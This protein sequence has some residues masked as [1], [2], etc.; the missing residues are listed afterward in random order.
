MP[1]YAK[2]LKDLLTNK[3]NLEEST[4]VLL[5]EGCSAFVRRQPQKLTDPGNFTIPCQIDDAEFSR[6]L[7]DSGGRS[8]RLA[9]NS[10]EWLRLMGIKRVQVER[11]RSPIRRFSRSRCFIGGDGILGSKNLGGANFSLVISY[12]FNSLAAKV[13][14]G[15]SNMFIGSAHYSAN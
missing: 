2:F 15:Q 1:R 8:D 5:G 10:E 7:A 6:A 14:I 3:K 12:G 11:G 9:E 4:T 13:L